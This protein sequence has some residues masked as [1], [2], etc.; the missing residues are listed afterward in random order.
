M[1]RT[2]SIFIKIPNRWS[3]GSAGTSAPVILLQA[4]LE[5]RCENGCTSSQSGSYSLITELAWRTV[6]R[7]LPGGVQASSGDWTKAE[8]LFVGMGRAIFSSLCLASAACTASVWMSAR[9][10]RR[11]AVSHTV[12]RRRDI[13]RVLEGRD[14]YRDLTGA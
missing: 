1:L 8:R 7:V 2:L 3:S 6:R 10:A 11:S 12:W 4:E 5:T 9:A 13:Y 14:P